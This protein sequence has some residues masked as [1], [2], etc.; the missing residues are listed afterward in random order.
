MKKKSDSSEPESLQPLPSPLETLAERVKSLLGERSAHAFAVRYGIPY[1]T[2]QRILQGK[3]TPKGKQLQA[4]AQA[5]EVTVDWLLYGGEKPQP[6]ALDSEVAMLE[7]G[8]ENV[9][10]PLIN[11]QVGAGNGYEVMTEEVS[12]YL[13]LPRR[14][15]TKERGLNPN[16]LHAVTVMGDSMSPEF[17]PG[18]I[19][20]LDVEKT[21][22]GEGIY[23]VRLDNAIVIKRMQVLAG[24]AIK[25][26]SHNPI[27][28]PITI[29]LET[30]GESFQILGRVVWSLRKF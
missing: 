28:E 7:L 25:L 14:L 11:L 22:P 2:L 26:N 12:E 27:Y 21:R 20:F 13:T 6:K 9:R 18:D 23:I 16:S 5:G 10:I 19:V 30:S 8:E 3:T 24:K 15:I 1:T 29:D 4:I 17:N